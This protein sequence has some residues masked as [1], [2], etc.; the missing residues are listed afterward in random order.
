MAPVDV[1]N[2]GREDLIY[3][4]T[5]VQEVTFSLYVKMVSIPQQI[6]HCAY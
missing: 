4:N 1:N 2:D 3:T 5:Q 6:I